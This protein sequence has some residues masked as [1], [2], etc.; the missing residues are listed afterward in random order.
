M[1]GALLK[2]QIR[3]VDA[4]PVR[5]GKEFG[6]AG[7]VQLVVSLFA[8]DFTAGVCCRPSLAALLRRPLCVLRWHSPL[9]DRYVERLELLEH[10][11]NAARAANRVARAD[12]LDLA[13]R[14]AHAVHPVLR[15]PQSNTRGAEG[16][17]VGSSGVARRRAHV[18]RG[19]ARGARHAHPPGGTRRV[20]GWNNPS[21]RRG[22]ARLSFPARDAFLTGVHRQEMCCLP[23]WPFFWDWRE[24]IGPNDT[25]QLAVGN[26]AEPL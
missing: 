16:R 1:V 12:D 20:A 24:Q 13:A 19:R 15:A 7:Y 3:L 23:R 18:G 4:Q 14:H 21:H 17:C 11:L 9:V 2:P 22:L 5:V 26:D 10:L 8:C 25:E 6:I